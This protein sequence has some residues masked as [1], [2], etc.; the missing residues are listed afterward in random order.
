V[1]WVVTMNL[2]FSQENEEKL[3]RT[4]NVKEQRYNT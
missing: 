4:I 3:S 2:L 1:C